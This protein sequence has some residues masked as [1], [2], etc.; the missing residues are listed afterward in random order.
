MEK[1]RGAL[2]GKKSIELLS[3]FLKEKKY[4]HPIKCTLYFGY[5]WCIRQ[6]FP[7]ALTHKHLTFL[8]VHLKLDNALYECIPL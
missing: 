8:S 6:R 5:C 3:G 2:T 1:Q 4:I 7:L